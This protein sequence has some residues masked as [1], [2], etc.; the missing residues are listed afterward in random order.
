MSSLPSAYRPS[1]E[2]EAYLRAINPWWIG[3]PGPL[4]PDY[5]RWAFPVLLRKLELGL[6]PVVALRG[7]RQVGKTTL[8]E[9]TIRH[10]L[11]EQDVPPRHIFRVQLDEIPSLRDFEMPLLALCGWFEHE[12]LGQSFNRA[13]HGGS[14]AYLFIDEIQNLGDWAPQL[15]ALVDHQSVK[16]VITGSSALSIAAG[17]DSLAGRLSSL[18]LGPLLLREIAGLAFGERIDP[19]LPYNGLEPLCD[20]SFWETVADSGKKHRDLRDRAFRAFSRRGGYPLAQVRREMPWPELAD[21]LNENVIQ[22]VLQH[23]LG[24]A[25]IP[26][27]EARDPVVLEAVFRLACRYAGQ[28]PGAKIF[29]RELRKMIGA[30]MTWQR[31]LADLRFLEGSLLLRLVPPL[32]MR[33]K[34][35]QGQFKLAILDL[36]LR[37]SWLGEV[38]P[39]DAEGLEASPH[40]SI[41]AGHLAESATAM[42]FSGLPHLQVAHF[43]ERPGEP[44]VDLV[45]TAGE[46][47]IPVEV[48]YRH[49]VDPPRDLAGIRSFLEKEH[50]NASFG[51]LVT[52]HDVEIDDPRIVAVPLSSLLFLR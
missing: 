25:E 28:A 27:G 46:Q 26:G 20:R 38:V 52:L 8:Q 49:R 36:A 37:A 21:Q 44:E 51:L 7:A 24:R 50:Y 35:H 1:P 31:V 39:L 18:E 11:T 42:F 4:L 33:A 12:V 41:L 6:A 22:R 48:K 9:Q 16:V 2:L 19:L 10:L 47:R 34:R 14:P 15:K 17:R 43:P 13:A 45:L 40:L 5:H 23:D 29:T 30:E 32:E 3:E